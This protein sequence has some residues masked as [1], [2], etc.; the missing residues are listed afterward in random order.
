MLINDSFL[1]RKNKYT[2]EFACPFSDG[3][4]EKLKRLSILS[5]SEQDILFEEISGFEPSI[6][7]FGTLPF[8]EDFTFSVEL[9]FFFNPKNPYLS[10]LEKWNEEERRQKIEQ[11]LGFP[12]PLGWKIS[13]ISD[14]FCEFN[15][16][17]P[18][19]DYHENTKEDWEALKKGLETI[20]KRL[21]AGWFSVHLHLG[22]RSITTSDNRLRVDPLK[23]GRLVKVYESMWRVLSGTGYTVKASNRVTSTFGMDFLAGRDLDKGVYHHCAM[24][25]LSKKFP[26]VE[27]KI[28]SGLLEARHLNVGCLQGDLYWTF[29]MLNCL[30]DRSRILPLATL[31][32]PIAS[33]EKPSMRRICHFL[34]MLYQEDVTGK[35]LAFRKFLSFD[36]CPSGASSMHI[37]VRQFEDAMI[38]DRLGLATVFAMHEEN[39]GWDEKIEERILRSPLLLKQLSEDLHAASVKH[40]LETYFLNEELIQRLQSAGE[41]FHGGHPSPDVSRHIDMS[42]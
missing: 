25:N 1:D 5:E 12:M 16:A 39:G 15:T 30:N 28:I 8:P 24:I 17:A 33:G 11:A 4:L 9:E 6:F 2:C 27:F 37:I 29:A 21:P 3:S 23:F 22:C 13:A 32:L 19:K 18:G 10:D 41:I 34:D 40:P 35:A 26:T 7:S 36:H 14:E 38:Y 20:Q 42:H 31:G